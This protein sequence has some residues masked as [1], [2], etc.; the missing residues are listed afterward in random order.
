MRNKYCYSFF[1]LL[2]IGVVVVGLTFRFGEKKKEAKSETLTVVT[3]FYPMYVATQNLIQGVDGIQLKNLSEPQTGCLH[4]FQLTPEDMKLLSKADVFV[5]NGSGAE[6]FLKDVVKAYP[7]LVTIDATEKIEDISEDVGMH[8][9][10]SPI[11]YEKE[12][13]AIAKGLMNVCPKEKTQINHN[14]A[15]YKKKVE[16]LCKEVARLKAQFDAESREHVILFS[17]A[18]EGLAEELGLSVSYL[19]DLDEERQISSGEV[20]EV[21]EAVSKDK[22]VFILAEDPYG[23]NLAEMV[24]KQTKT[25]V[26]YVDTLTRGQYDKNRY[27]EGMARNLKAIKEALYET[28]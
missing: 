14:A 4:D 3:S 11:L 7:R 20:A 25:P 21:M 1:M 12:V 13:D 10:M 15:D 27:V 23:K 18:Y 24:S 26:V 17:E 2:L 6:A 5:V 9:W 8:A 16:T 28:D 22:R 19:M